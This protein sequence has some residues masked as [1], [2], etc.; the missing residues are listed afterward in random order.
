MIIV[1]FVWTNIPIFLAGFITI[2][3]EDDQFYHIMHI[4]LV[5]IFLTFHES[6]IFIFLDIFLGSFLH[7]SGHYE[8]YVIFWNRVLCIHH[9]FFPGL[10]F[11]FFITVIILT[12][13]VYV[14][15]MIKLSNFWSRYYV[16]DYIY[17]Y[18]LPGSM[19][20]CSK[21]KNC[22]ILQAAD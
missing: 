11:D 16:M 18:L 13:F 20:F 6:Q 21:L 4:I 5:W 2:Y 8:S 17:K 15:Y 22:I 7:S 9:I 19:L 10:I 1:V 14:Q 12:I 3:F